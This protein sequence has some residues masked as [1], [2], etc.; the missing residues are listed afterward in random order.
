MPDLL[1]SYRAGGPG[2]DE[3]LQAGGPAR[4]AWAQ[5]AEHAHLGQA[6]ELLS[7]QADVVALLQDQGVTYGETTDG[8]RVS[9]LGC[10]GQ[11]PD[12]PAECEAQA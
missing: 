10:T 7:R 6:E 8:W 9:A 2:P 4:V 1:E 3:M 12:T 11:T 5:L